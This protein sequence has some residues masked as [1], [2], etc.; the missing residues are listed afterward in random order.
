MK[1]ESDIH[2][3]L[4]LQLDMLPKNGRL[5]FAILT[6]PIWLLVTIVVV[7]VDAFIKFVDEATKKSKK[8]RGKKN[9][10]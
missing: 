9:G 7:I 5:A 6:I 1:T 2:K 3:V 4:K 8:K 10:K